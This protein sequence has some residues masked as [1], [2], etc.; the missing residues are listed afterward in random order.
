MERNMLSTHA[1]TL[2]T[3]AMPAAILASTFWTQTRPAGP[4]GLS[5]EIG[6]GLAISGL[7]F[8]AAARIQLNRSFSIRA[9]ATEL[10][11]LGIYSR[12][13]NPVY[14]FGTIFLIG[15]ILWMGRPMWL[16][17]LSVIVPMQ[18]VRAQKEAQVLEE[19][20]GDAYRAYRAKTWF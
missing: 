17:A 10:V 9:K 20:F 11:T 7:I 6:L 12:I 1:K 19:K 14:L 2:I 8:W 18:V 15:L 13:R 5:R 16:L 4:L 3:V